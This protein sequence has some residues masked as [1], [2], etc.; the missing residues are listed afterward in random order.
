MLREGAPDPRS[1]IRSIVHQ[2]QRGRRRAMLS[3]ADGCLDDAH[4][5]GPVLA[6]V[7]GAIVASRVFELFVMGEGIRSARRCRT[8]PSARLSPSL[9]HPQR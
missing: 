3:R 7:L 2:M 9:C 5:Y 8:P 6:Q 4:R 1:S